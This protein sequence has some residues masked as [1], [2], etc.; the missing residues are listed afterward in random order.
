LLGNT[1]L[2]EQYPHL[3]NLARRK[4]DTV[5]AVLSTQPSS[6]SWRRDLLGNKLVMW[7]NLLSRL[8]HVALRQEEDEFLWNLDQKIEFLVKS[9]YLG[10]IYQNVPNLNNRLWKLKAPLKIKIFL[11]YLRRGVILTKDNLAK[12][13]WQGSKQYCFCHENE[14][15]Q[16]LFLDCRFARLVW[17]SVLAAWGL[18]RPLNVSNIFGRWLDGLRKHLK[19]LVL[20]R[21]ATMCWS[22][23]LYRNAAIFEN[24]QPSFMQVIYSTMHRLRTWSI[25][26]KPTSQEV[27]VAAS[28]FLAQVAKEI[29]A[30]AHGCQSNLRI[31]SH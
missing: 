23:W 26:Q 28:Q 1:A 22:L 17:G 3:Y 9:H 31:E 4:Q 14:T 29:F 2:K 15:I 25:L 10:L 6:V 7:N 20:L 27:V 19:P 24:K 21:A 18:P 8:T 16:H 13:K 11:W 5:A 30:R 12:R